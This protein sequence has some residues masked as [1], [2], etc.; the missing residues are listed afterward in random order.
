MQNRRLAMLLAVG[1]FAQ[2]VTMA[3]SHFGK[4]FISAQFTQGFFLGSG[5]MVEAIV[6]A[7]MVKA[8]VDTPNTHH[9]SQGE[10]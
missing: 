4:V 2:V 10:E 9:P 7:L 5:V 6:V 1:G 8:A 3:A